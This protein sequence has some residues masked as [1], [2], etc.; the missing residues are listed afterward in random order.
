MGADTDSGSGTVIAV[1]AGGS[2]SNIR[3]LLATISDDYGD[4]EGVALLVADNTPDGS[5]E[6][7]FDEFAA[8]FRGGA[9]YVREPSRGYSNVRNSILENLG[10]AA[11]VAMIDDDEFPSPGWLDNLL[12]A[13][14]RS[15]ADVVA[16]PVVTDFPD[17][18]PR[19]FA[20]SRVF[21]IERPDL[22]EGAEMR[23]CASNN[24][25]A[26]TSAL[27]K[28]EGGFDA[29]LNETGGTDTDFFSRARLAGCRIVWTRSA[30]VHEPVP[31]KRLTRRWI[32]R[33]A[34]RAGNTRA[35]SEFRYSS[36][37]GTAMSTRALKA[38]ALM[39]YGIW[40]AL[41]SLARNDRAGSLKALYRIGQSY[42][43][44][45]AFVDRRPLGP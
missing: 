35:L 45:V 39:I 13:Q 15:G 8:K 3:R 31:R 17:D 27:G 28:V 4:R 16:G 2:L 43:M 9:R 21:D 5:S 41:I 14:A 18:A 22:P 6:V 32:F 19:T 37:L 38:S 23:W 29:R 30:V 34:A 1:P 24:T 33:R 12:A 11:F 44:A 20:E 10:D 26:R 7:A 42:G 36:S 25:L 40:W